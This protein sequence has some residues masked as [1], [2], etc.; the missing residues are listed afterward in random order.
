[1]AKTPKSD[2]KKDPEFQ[3]VVQHFLKTPPQPHKPKQTYLV[4]DGKFRVAGD[5]RRNNDGSITADVYRNLDDFRSGRTME[6]AA[7]FTEG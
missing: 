7:V 6:R 5:L 3:K 2:P 1:M 4:V